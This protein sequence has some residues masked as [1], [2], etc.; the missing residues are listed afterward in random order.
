MVLR[1]EH[2]ARDGQIQKAEVAW[3]CGKTGG[4]Q[5]PKKAD[6]QLTPK[7]GQQGQAAQVLNGLCEGGFRESEAAAQ[8]GA[9][10][11]G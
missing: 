2:S 3:P 11:S 8:L 6:A 5:T 4:Y 9:I 10:S 1:A 7:Q